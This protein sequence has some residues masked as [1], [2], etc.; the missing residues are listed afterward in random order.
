MLPCDVDPA[1]GQSTE[2]EIAFEFYYCLSE[3]RF[4]MLQPVHDVTLLCSAL[5]VTGRYNGTYKLL[6]S[7]D[8]Q[9]SEDSPHSPPN[10]CSL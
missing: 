4:Y 8:F 10:P 1:I 6:S 5:Q 2:K 7:A 3:R 9:N